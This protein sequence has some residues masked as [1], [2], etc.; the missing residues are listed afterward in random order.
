MAAHLG[1]HMATMHGARRPK[2]APAAG[3]PRTLGRPPMKTGRGPTGDGLGRIVSSMRSYR[4]SLMQQQGE[5]EQQISA[6]DGVLSAMGMRPGPAGRS[7]G[8]PARAAARPSL[9]GGPRRRRRRYEVSGAESL[10]GFVRQAGARGVT[11]GDLVRHWASENRRGSAYNEI[12]KLV[13]ARKLKKEPLGDQ[14]GSR[15][16]L[17]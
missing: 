15:Y 8:R 2:P 13:Q 7:I 17:G 1:R 6:I 5:L 3:K 11:T 12:G 9:T 10:L 14:R 4:D 16:T